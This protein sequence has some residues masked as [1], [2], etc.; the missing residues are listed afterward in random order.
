[1]DTCA[2]YKFYKSAI[3]TLKNKTTKY[4]PEENSLAK[5]KVPKKQSLVRNSSCT[6]TESIH[7]THDDSYADEY[8]SIHI[9]TASGTCKISILF[10]KSKL[11]FDIL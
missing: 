7:E 6:E 10:I 1:M 2:F 9:G 8:M 5:T 3:S 11:K 4:T